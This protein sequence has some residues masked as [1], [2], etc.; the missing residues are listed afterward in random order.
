MNRERTFYTLTSTEPDA[1][2]LVFDAFNQLDAESAHGRLYRLGAEALKD[3]ELLE[4]LLHPTDASMKEGSS[5]EKL[6][7]KIGGLHRMR[8]SSAEEL[9]QIGSITPIQALIIKAALELGKRALSYRRIREKQVT[10][11]QDIVNYLM[12]ELRAYETERFICV[13]LDT[14]NKIIKWDEISKGSMDG[15]M[16]MPRD[17][18]RPVIRDGAHAVIVVH[19]HPSGDPNPSP[20]DISVTRRLAQAAALLGIRF[21]DHIIIGDGQH[22]SLKDMGLIDEKNNATL[23]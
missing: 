11:P 7:E 2:D 18:F 19:N 6:T 12:P 3:S 5:Y 4:I 15:T 1:H 22:R 20:A 17:V 9:C 21:L 8:V 23:T 10:S 16:S 14:K 13:Q